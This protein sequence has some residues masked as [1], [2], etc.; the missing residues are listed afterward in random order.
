MKSS[1]LSTAAVGDPAAGLDP[2][3]VRVLDRAAETFA[4]LS[5]PVRLRILHA[6]CDGEKAVSEIVAIVGQSQTNVSQHL[7]L[8]HRAGILRR[9]RQGAQVFY[10]IAEPAIVGVCRLVCTLVAATS[11]TDA[12]EFGAP[13]RSSRRGPRR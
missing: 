5:G 6:V 10:E 1:T 8:M 11:D 9:R 12:V 7:S 4:V 3:L 13:R 2:D